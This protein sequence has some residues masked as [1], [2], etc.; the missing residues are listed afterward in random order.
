MHT[1]IRMSVPNDPL[2]LVGGRES[3]NDRELGKEGEESD[4]HFSCLSR[5]MES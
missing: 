4:N 5:E 1:N 3:R 2:C